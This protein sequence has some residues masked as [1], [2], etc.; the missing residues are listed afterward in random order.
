MIYKIKLPSFEGPFDLL[1]FL[2]KKN[3][4]DIYDI[5]IADITHQYLEYLNFMKMLNLDIAGEF[6][7]MI[8]TLMLIKVR[9]LLPRPV[10][11]IDEEYEDP[12]SQLVAQ[13]LEYKQYI[14]SLKGH[15]LPWVTSKIPAENFIPE[16]S[17]VKIKFYPL[18]KMEIY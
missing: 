14:N 6:I 7:E 5:P 3:E 2:I 1:L 8:A 18:R 13:L 12:R 9:M 4:V 16:E 15:L 10:G 11:Q 17:P